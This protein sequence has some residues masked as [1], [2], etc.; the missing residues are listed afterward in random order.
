[1]Q[2]TQT[3]PQT[4]EQKL[5]TLKVIWL[6]MAVSPLIYLLLAFLQLHNETRLTERTKIAN[7]IWLFAVVFAGMGM[8]LPNML[9]REAKPEAKLAGYIVRYALFETVA[10]CALVNFLA[11]GVT[12]IESAIGIL[13]AFALIVFHKPRLG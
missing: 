4:L 11:Q 1:M 7:L 3:A 8:L 13:L 5:K 10:I 9:F 6:A 2:Q 12:F